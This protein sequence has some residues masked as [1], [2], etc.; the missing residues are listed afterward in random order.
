MPV[1]VEGEAVL[2]PEGPTGVAVAELPDPPDPPDP[3][4]P[5]AVAV[6][7]LEGIEP[8][9]APPVAVERIMVGR[10]RVVGV[11][12]GRVTVDRVDSGQ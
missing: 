10:V 1:Y 12:A 11:V 5:V 4:P 2:V 6:P 8:P 7:L 3:E 9:V